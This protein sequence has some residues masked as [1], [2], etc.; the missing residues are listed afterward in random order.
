MVEYVQKNGTNKEIGRSGQTEAPHK[1]SI[2]KPNATRLFYE[3]LTMMASPSG[4]S[5]TVS[6]QDCASSRV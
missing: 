2:K 3:A 4:A 5:V 1:D 6:P